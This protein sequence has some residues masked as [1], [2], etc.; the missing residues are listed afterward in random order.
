MKTTY[1]I[2]GAVILDLVDCIDWVIEN[3]WQ[4]VGLIATGFLLSNLIG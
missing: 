4:T 3:P 2:I 1:K